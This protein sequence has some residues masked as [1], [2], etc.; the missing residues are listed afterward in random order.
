MENLKDNS[1]LEILQGLEGFAQDLLRLRDFHQVLMEGLIKGRDY[2]EYQGPRAI[3]L[4]PGAEKISLILGLTASI[5]FWIG[6][7]I[8]RGD[9]LPIV[10]AVVSL[11][12]ER[13]WQRA[14]GLA[15]ARRSPI[16]PVGIA[17]CLV[18]PA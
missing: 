10:S 2:G 12:M 1:G 6:W 11:R 16:W 18:I 17:T 9:F 7:R 13:S 3:L 15:I 8:I 5:L 14:W 4:K